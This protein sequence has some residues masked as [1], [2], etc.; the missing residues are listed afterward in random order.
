MNYEI[1]GVREGDLPYLAEN[2]RAADVRELMATY[3]HTRFLSGLERSVH[4]SEEALVG[5]PFGSRP[6]LLWGIRQFT[7]RAALIWACGT[8][9]ILK[10][11]RAVVENS[12]K[13]IARWFVERPGVDFFM[14]FSHASN[15]AHHRWLE[16]CGAEM[17][18]AL[19]MG[20]LGELFMPFTIRRTKYN[21]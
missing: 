19:P 16:W 12:R 8:P 7:P 4:L 10:H 11:K 17:L 20:P 1:R 14:N 9:E 21:V 6:A 5:A 3:G 13:I 2:L 18:P 15:A